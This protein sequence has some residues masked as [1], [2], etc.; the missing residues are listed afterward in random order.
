MVVHFF[1]QAKRAEALCGAGFGELGEESAHH[2]QKYK[3][4]ADSSAGFFV[5]AGGV[6]PPSLWH[7]INIYRQSAGASGLCAHRF[8]RT[9]FQLPFL[10]RCRRK[11]FSHELP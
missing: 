5:G 7:Y 2:H 4:P 10:T 11:R 9:V 6:L 3:K 8:G 1:G